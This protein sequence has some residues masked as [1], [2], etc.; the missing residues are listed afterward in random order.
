MLDCQ[1]CGACC[2]SESSSYVPLTGRDRLLLRG[3]TAALVREVDGAH[4]MA[5]DRGR[6]AALRVHRGAFVCAIY[7]RRPAV[8][9]ELDR[10]TPACREER[11]LKR[12]VA[13][14]ARTAGDPGSSSPR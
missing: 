12:P 1:S 4:Y 7:A 11:A 3:D 13:A 9:R 2:F 10:G 8:C 6:C 14:E 5:M